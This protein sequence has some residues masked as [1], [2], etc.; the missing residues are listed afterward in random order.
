MQTSL[1]SG[2][3]GLHIVGNPA[4]R[5]SKALSVGRKL[6]HRPAPKRTSAEQEDKQVSGGERIRRVRNVRATY[7]HAI[8][9]RS[10]EI[11][12]PSDLVHRESGR[13]CID[14]FF[15]LQDKGGVG[16]YE[17]ESK[18]TSSNGADPSNLKA[19]AELEKAIGQLPPEQQQQLGRLYMFLT[20]HPEAKI[21]LQDFGDVRRAL[22]NYQVCLPNRHNPT[23]LCSTL[24]VREH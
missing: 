21:E 23:T 5:S 15:C 22:D 2:S 20:Q 8:F 11:R 3:S 14:V 18:S 9:I 1:V 7:L 16:L 19:G 13:R 6:H 4:V 24:S 17:P 10:H 12:W